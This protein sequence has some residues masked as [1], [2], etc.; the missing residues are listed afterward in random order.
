MKFYYCEYCGVKQPN[1]NL[2]VTGS[3][4]YTGLTAATS[5]TRARKSPCTTAS[6]AGQSIPT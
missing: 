3:C 1:L 4:L 2:L 6:I 5:C